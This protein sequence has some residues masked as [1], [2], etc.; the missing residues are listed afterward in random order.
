MLGH[1]YAMRPGPRSAAIA[2]LIVASVFAPTTVFADPTPSPSPEATRSPLEQYKIDREIYLEAIKVRS[3]QMR[4]I[5]NIFKERCD[6]AARDYKNAMSIARTLDQ[7][8]LAATLRKNAVNAAIAA[9]DAAI[10]QLGPEP[11]PP[12][13]PA[14]PLKFSSKKKQR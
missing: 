4:I 2:A 13:E 10:Y 14:K 6:K 1:T 9:R 7:K 8:N 5:N 12:I 3:Q 11:I